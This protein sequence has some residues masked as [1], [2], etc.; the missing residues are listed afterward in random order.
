MAVSLPNSGSDIAA[1]GVRIKKLR[2]KRSMT[3]EDLGRK[4]ELS[5]SFLSLVERDKAVPSIVSLVNIARSLEVE[6]DYFIK[7]PAVSGVLHRADEP[8]Y[9]EIDS[10]INFIRLSASLSD[11]KLDAFI[12]EI[13]AGVIL[14]RE[15]AKGEFF[16]YLL[17]GELKISAGTECYTIAPGDSLHFDATNGYL[18]ENPSTDMARVLWV[19]SP[20]L[21]SPSPSA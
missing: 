3:L 16:Y 5:P 8:E 14:P 12:F 7:P 10:P 11:P 15:S 9:L 21:L 18:V 1:F 13:P 6:I 17:S 20:P 19:G 2:K 4:A